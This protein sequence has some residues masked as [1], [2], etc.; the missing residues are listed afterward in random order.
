MVEFASLF[1][2][3]KQPRELLGLGHSLV[4]LGRF[5]LTA[6]QAQHVGR[7]ERNFVGDSRSLIPIMTINYTENHIVNGTFF[8]G[9]IC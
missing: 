1:Y 5:C 6:T 7:H 2:G 9:Y 8:V 3:S 4:V